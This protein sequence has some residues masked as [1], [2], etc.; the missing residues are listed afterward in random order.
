[1]VVDILLAWMLSFLLAVLLDWA[2]VL[3]FKK[4]SVLFPLH[5]KTLLFIPVALCY[6]VGIFLLGADNIRDRT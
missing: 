2:N 1:M 4:Q 3:L 5:W 6:V